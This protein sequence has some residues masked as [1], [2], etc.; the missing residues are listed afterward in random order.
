MLPNAGLPYWMIEGLAVYAETK[1]ED[2]RGYHPYYDMM[3]RTEILE[4]DFKN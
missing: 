4:Q 3:M 2:G 1:F